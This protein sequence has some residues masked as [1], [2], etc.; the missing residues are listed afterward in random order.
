MTGRH[1][2]LFDGHCGFCRRAV[3]RVL[4]RD[5]Q[6]L[7]L[8][9]PYQ[10]APWPPMTATLSKACARAVH[11]VRTDGKVL[12]GGRAV[13]FILERTGLGAPA[14]L[15]AR[16]PF[17]WVVELAYLTVARYRTFFSRFL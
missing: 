17:I 16:P 9:L 12:R 15:L 6:G 11:V 13:L 7:F 10:E 4:S 14:Q 5:R 1:L 2:I 3:T 8:A